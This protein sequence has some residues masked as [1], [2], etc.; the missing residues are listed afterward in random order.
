MLLSVGG[1]A[2]GKDKYQ[3]GY[4]PPLAA[5]D[6]PHRAVDTAKGDRSVESDGAQG[7]QPFP[8]SEFETQDAV[9]IIEFKVEEV[10]T[11]FA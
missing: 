5:K 1:E 7:V 9:Q 3:I 6:Q 8:V 10:E 11:A 4:G 2:M